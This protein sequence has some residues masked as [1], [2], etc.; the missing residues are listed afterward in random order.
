MWLVQLT[1][2]GALHF[3]PVLH[4]EEGIDEEEQSSYHLN[5]TRDKQ[6]VL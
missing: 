4:Y 2:Y 1:V 3:F 5:E 6:R